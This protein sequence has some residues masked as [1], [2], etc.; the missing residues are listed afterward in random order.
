MSDF[1]SLFAA[2]SHMK[3][4][5]F[6]AALLNNHGRELFRDP[7]DVR[8]EMLLL[9]RL[10]KTQAKKKRRVTIYTKDGNI[11]KR[12][13][14]DY[15][16]RTKR[17]KAAD[18]WAVPFLQLIRDAN[19]NDPDHPTGKEFRRSFR[20]PYPV[21]NRIVQLCR[22]SNDKLFNYPDT[23]IDGTTNIP[24]ELKILMVLRTLAGG[25]QFKDA[26]STDVN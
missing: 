21:F 22:D 5:F 13:R 7:I 4:N 16:R 3:R 11:S 17:I 6:H 9:R 25:L 8:I 15:S 23:N 24:L 1:L 19:V 20:I 26:R 12:Q 10:T 2:E 14:L 18:P